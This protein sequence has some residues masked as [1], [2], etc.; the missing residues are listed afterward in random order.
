M[1]N[2]KI[3]KLN[4]NELSETFYVNEMSETFHSPFSFTGFSFTSF[5]HIN[6]MSE[7]FDF[8]AMNECMN[9]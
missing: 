4:V 5:I 6:A 1:M 9:E 7:T 3:E 8:N 2:I